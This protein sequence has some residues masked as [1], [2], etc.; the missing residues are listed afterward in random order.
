MKLS[1]KGLATKAAAGATL[2]LVMAK[3]AF[4]Y[5][6]ENIS[7]IKILG[8][9]EDNSLMTVVGNIV[10]VLLWIIGILAVLYLVYGGVLYITAGGEAEKATKGRTAITNA[11]IGIIIIVLALLIYN[12][13]L[14]SVNT[15]A[16][17]P[18]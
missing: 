3:S 10:G 2:G 1:I 12:Y 13:V 15:G 9:Q 8:S 6:L 18:S 14:G 17:I 16:N 7:P 11:I 4:A 5:S